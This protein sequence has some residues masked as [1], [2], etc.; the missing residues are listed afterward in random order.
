MGYTLVHRRVLK[1]HYKYSHIEDIY[2]GFKISM[3]HID[4]HYEIDCGLYK[5]S[6]AHTNKR[7]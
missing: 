3:T 2:R 7:N 1:S 5:I 4:S 6:V